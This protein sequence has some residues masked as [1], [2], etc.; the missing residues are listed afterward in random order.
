MV[1]QSSIDA[2]LKALCVRKGCGHVRGWHIGFHIP[3]GTNS[4]YI[5]SL[6]GGACNHRP[7]VCQEFVEPAPLSIDTPKG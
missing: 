5:L 1:V 6:K 7:C 2:H 3:S 4:V